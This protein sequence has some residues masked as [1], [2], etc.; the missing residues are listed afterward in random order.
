MPEEEYAVIVAAGM[1][2]RMNSEVPK[3]F[4]PV[5]GF[6][7]LMHTI[8]IFHEYSP[9]IKLVV[10]L[11]GRDKMHWMKLCDEYHF[12]IPIKVAVGGKT[13]FQSVQNG[14]KQIGDEGL[15]AIHDGVR[16]L[17]DKAIIGASFHLASVHGCAIASVRLKES[18]RM[19]DKD[20]TKSVDRSKFRLI[21]TPQTFQI[22]VI[23][24]AYQQEESPS[25]TDDASVAENA[26][27]KISLFEG[28]YKNIKITTPDDL[29]VASLFL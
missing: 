13:R 26:G 15:V 19:I 11:S 14:L 23:K 12:N 4:I 8:R 1:G 25:F 6:P 3:Q 21:Q 22:P 29:L 9:Q 20:K 7:I 5:H 28:S 10:V 24:K 18:I 27:F 16:P 2:T 17:V